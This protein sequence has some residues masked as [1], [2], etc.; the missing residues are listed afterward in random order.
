MLIVAGPRIVFDD[1]PRQQAQLFALRQF[2]HVSSKM[3]L[4]LRKPANL[5]FDAGLGIHKGFFSVS[6]AVQLWAFML[7]REFQEWGMQAAGRGIA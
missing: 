2:R 1:L 5:L 3:R 4:I 6:A 7:A